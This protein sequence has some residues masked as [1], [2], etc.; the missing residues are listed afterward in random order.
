VDLFVDFAFELKY[1]GD[2]VDVQQ[3]QYE[4]Q[5]LSERLLALPFLI[6]H[7]CVSVQRV[8]NYINSKKV[9]IMESDSKE[10]SVVDQ[11]LGQNTIES[12]KLFNLDATKSTAAPLGKRAGAFI[13]DKLILFFVANSLRSLSFRNGYGAIFIPIAINVLAEFI[14]AGYFYSTHSATVGKMVFN[15]QVV[16]ISNEKLSFLEAGLRDSLGK[17]IS[18]S[19][20]GI[21]YLIAFFRRD[22]YALHDLIFKTK[23]ITK[24]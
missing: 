5:N 15:L 8:Y 16:K 20:L 14:Y 13:L 6:L 11:Y 22:K 2:E 24:N 21:G 12:Q 17:I 18:S 1:S 10:K 7:G 23:V 3:W 19:L 9:K 4:Y